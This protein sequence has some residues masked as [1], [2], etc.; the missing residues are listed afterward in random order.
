MRRR[1]EPVMDA[2]HLLL[3]FGT[4]AIVVVFVVLQ[5]S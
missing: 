5:L 2:L 3:I 1:R 4:I